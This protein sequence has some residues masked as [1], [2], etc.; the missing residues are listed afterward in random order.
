MHMLIQIYTCALI[1]TKVENMSKQ[2]LCFYSETKCT[3]GAT[4]TV[5]LVERSPLALGFVGSIPTHVMWALW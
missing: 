2:A 4:A 5:Q 1:Y 3:S